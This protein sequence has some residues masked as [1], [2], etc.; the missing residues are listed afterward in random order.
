[1]GSYA[2]RVPGPTALGFRVERANAII[3]YLKIFH[4]RNRRHNALGMR[5]PIEYGRIHDY[6]LTTAPLI[7]VS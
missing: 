7:Q 3:E 6:N 2:G 1:M 4:K 5:S